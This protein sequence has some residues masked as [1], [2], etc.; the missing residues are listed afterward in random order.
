M[1]K[2]AGVKNLRAELKKKKPNLK[3]LMVTVEEDAERSFAVATLFFYKLTARRYI[4]YEEQYPELKEVQKKFPLVLEK[5]ANSEFVQDVFEFTKNEAEKQMVRL[6]NEAQKPQEQ[7]VEADSVPV[8]KMD[9]QRVQAS[10]TINLV[11]SSKASMSKGLKSDYF[12][13]SQE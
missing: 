10:S 8:T 3:K 2:E 13:K 12:K 7:S 4:G 5:D 6:E 11:N 9:S 1:G